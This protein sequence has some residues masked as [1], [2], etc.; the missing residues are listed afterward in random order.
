MPTFASASGKEDAGAISPPFL[1][2]VSE[3]W[4]TQKKCYGG[5]AI[6]TYRVSDKHTHTHTK[7]SVH[8][9]T[10]IHTYIHTYMHMFLYMLF[11]HTYLPT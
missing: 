10:Y 8:K 7:K 6:G 1:V 5:A 2:N 3:S 4:V 11:T 9:Q